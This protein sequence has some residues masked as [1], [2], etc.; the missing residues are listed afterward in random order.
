MRNYLLV[1]SLKELKSWHA[2]GICLKV[3]E[4]NCLMMLHTAEIALDFPVS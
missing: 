1:A 2:L 3:I 4:M